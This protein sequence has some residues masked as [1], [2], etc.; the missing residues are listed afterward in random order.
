[1]QRDVFAFPTAGSSKLDCW[2]ACFSRE[3]ASKPLTNS[4]QKESSPII[5]NGT[6]K[7]ISCKNLARRD[8]PLRRPTSGKKKLISH[9]VVPTSP[10][11][12]NSF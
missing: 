1:M 9:Y 11:M 2:N 7:A 4:L 8:I 5:H 10:S 6:V 3:I 12:V